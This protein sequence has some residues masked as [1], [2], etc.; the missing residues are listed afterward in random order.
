LPA[1][2]FIAIR[3]ESGSV[4]S[5]DKQNSVGGDRAALQLQARRVTQP[6]RTPEA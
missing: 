2:S 3:E 1:A 5:I 4:S 6:R